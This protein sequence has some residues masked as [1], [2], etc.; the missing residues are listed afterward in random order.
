M[1]GRTTEHEVPTQSLRHISSA[2]RLT[3]RCPGRNGTQ[4]IVSFLTLKLPCVAMRMDLSCVLWAPGGAVQAH[5][6]ANPITGCFPRVQQ[7]GP[8]RRLDTMLVCLGEALGSCRTSSTCNHA[9]TLLSNCPT[10]WN[11]GIWGLGKAQQ[12]SPLESPCTLH[13]AGHQVRGCVCV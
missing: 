4:A 9:D 2:R 1:E 13:G 7:T 10:G 3:P 12:G 6:A 5:T 8:E 11:T